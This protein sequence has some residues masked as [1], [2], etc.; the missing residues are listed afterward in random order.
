M[1]LS[2]L[3][4]STSMQFMD[5]RIRDKAFDIFNA[6]LDEG[7]PDEQAIPIAMAQAKKWAQLR[8]H[9]HDLGFSGQCVH[10]VPHPDGWAVRRADAL[11]SSFVFTKMADAKTKAL[12]IGKREQVGIVLHDEYGEVHQHIR[13]VGG[14]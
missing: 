3:Y 12:E 1:A 14:R 5:A 6:L 7:Y 8:R 10:V 4:Y 2:Q 9:T 11:K 13:P